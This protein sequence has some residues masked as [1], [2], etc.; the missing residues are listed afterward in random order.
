MAATCCWWCCCKLG[1]AAD[2]ALAAAA[3]GESCC[4]SAA[5]TAGIDT[6]RY[7]V[8]VFV[9]SAVFASLAGSL[10]A[11]A[12]RFVTP[13]EG[14]FLRSIE[15]VTMVVLGGMASTFGAVVGALILTVLPQLLTAVHEYKHVALGIIMISVMIF[16]PRGLVPTLMT[17]WRRYRA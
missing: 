8:L 4:R 13:V 3:T 15:F 1:D 11:H 12:E 7:K 9:V 6:T 16:M 17:L 14:D 5:E 2:V 10:F